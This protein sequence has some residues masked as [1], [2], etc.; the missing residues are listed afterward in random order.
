MPTYLLA[1]VIYDHA[2]YYNVSSVVSGVTVNTWARQD[3]LDQA[4]YANSISGTIL[5]TL[6]SYL[7][8]PFDNAKIDQVTIPNFFIG[9]MENW[10]LITYA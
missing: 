4:A 9:A 8:T 7:N 10:G 5:T 3:L 2:T 1:W 6:W